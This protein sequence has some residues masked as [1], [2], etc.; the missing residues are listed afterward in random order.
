[1]WFTTLP[2]I[3]YQHIQP[4]KIRISKAPDF[5]GKSLTLQKETVESSLTFPNIDQPPHAGEN[6]HS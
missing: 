4:A 5:N 1:M 6:H 2:L 3:S